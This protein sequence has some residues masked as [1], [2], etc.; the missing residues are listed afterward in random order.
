MS[1]RN[2][3]WFILINKTKPLIGQTNIEEELRLLEEKAK[4][5]YGAYEDAL[6]V[7]KDLEEVWITYQKFTFILSSIYNFKIHN[8]IMCPLILLML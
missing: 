1:L 5:A 4:E 2:W 6:N 7:T 3:G 8:F